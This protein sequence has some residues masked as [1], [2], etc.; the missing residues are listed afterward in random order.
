MMEAYDE[1]VHTGAIPHRDIL[2]RQA[3]EKGVRDARG[4]R[5]PLGSESDRG[6]RLLEILYQK[7]E[8]N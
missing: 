1:I 3:Q 6:F 4:R 7:G 8:E 2:E 5:Q